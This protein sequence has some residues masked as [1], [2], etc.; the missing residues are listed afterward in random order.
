MFN[1][2]IKVTKTLIL[3]VAL[4]MAST[5]SYAQFVVKVRPVRPTTVVVRRPAAPSPR[6]VWVEEDWVPKGNTY[7]WHGG[8]Y[9]APPRNGA[10]YVRGHWRN[11]RR[12]SV[13]V[14]GRWR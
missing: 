14:A 4:F 9:A 10:R 2:M 7:V 12:G 5:A 13:W 6:H 11:T 1:M 8:Y 3:M